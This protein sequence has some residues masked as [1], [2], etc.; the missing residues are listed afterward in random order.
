MLELRLS[1]N[2]RIHKATQWL[3]LTAGMVEKGIHA[4]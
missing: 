2:A 1:V 3:L 4:L